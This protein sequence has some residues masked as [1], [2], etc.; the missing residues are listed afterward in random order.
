[1]KGL[2]QKKKELVQ[3]VTLHDLD[4]ANAKPQGGQD[5]VTVV[6]QMMK[7]RKTEITEKLRLEVNKVF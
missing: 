3:N 7:Q 4:W 5:I 2:V 6:G 1:M